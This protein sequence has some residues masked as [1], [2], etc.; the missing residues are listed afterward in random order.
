MKIPELLAPAGNKEKAV[1][2]MEYGADAIYLAGKAFGMRAKAGNFSADELKEV[3]ELA[4]ER[5]VKVYVTV[6]TYPRN[7]EMD[8]LPAYLQEL[9]ELE[10]D[11]LIV[12][13]VG[14][15]ALARQYAPSI[16]VHLSTQANTV[17]YQA[18]K[19]WEELG[20]SRL[21]LARELS[22]EEIAR[23]RQETGLELEV[24]VHGAMCVA[25]SGRC[26]LSNVLAG[27]DANRGECAQSCRW[28]YAVVEEKRP[29]EYMP[30]EEDE[31]GTHI[32]NSK[33]LRL[34]E[35]I[36]DLV[37]MGVD[38][39]KTE[40]RMKS[41]Y[42]VATVVRAYRQALDLY[43]QDP[44][45]YKL[46]PEL[47]DELD[48]VSHRPYWAGFFAPTDAGIHRPSS[49]YIQTHEV[50]GVVESYDE[51]RGE[52]VVGVRNR[53][54]LGAEVEVMQPR[55][56]IVKAVISRL[57]RV[58]PEEE[59]ETAHANFKVRIPMEQVKPYS[60]LRMKVD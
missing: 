54:P 57:T 31:G 13:D 42:Y 7:E 8:Q 11:A 4:K 58:E 28:R 50:V 10:V 47:L 20:F 38:S 41:A 30:I 34:I 52:A 17:N 12:A 2:A 55:A 44:A 32:F 24:F 19:F 14:V 46:P 40:G 39:L 59:L 35:Y 21:V 23:V 1:V 5:G 15:F 18:A 22:R 16:P 56:S 51:A 27:R 60:M 37:R 33:D 6:N 45:G 26:L 53:L 43:A 3:L 25:Y 9:E 49:A 36:P 48:K 29:G